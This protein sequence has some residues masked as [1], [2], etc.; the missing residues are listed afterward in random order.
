MIE[1]DAER[2]GDLQLPVL[3]DGK[4]ERP[5]ETELYSLRAE[6]G[7]RYWFDVIAAEKFEPRIALLGSKKSWFDPSRPRRVLLDEERDLDL[8]PSQPTSSV[9]VWR[10]RHGASIRAPV[11]RR[12]TDRFLRTY[13][14]RRRQPAAGGLLPGR[15]RS[16][17]SR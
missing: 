11:F 5:G 3:I 12:L 16:G 2:A 9:V 10:R 4:I 15:L 7:L 14:R 17:S 1:D 8:V 6:E 13:G